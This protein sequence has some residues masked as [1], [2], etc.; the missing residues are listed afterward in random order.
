MLVSFLLRFY[1]VGRGQI[2]L[3]GVDLRKLG[4]QTLRSH[5]AVVPQDSLLFSRDIAGNI[6]LGNGG[7]L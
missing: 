6:R 2:L 4:L 7:F 3:D 1:D 5:F